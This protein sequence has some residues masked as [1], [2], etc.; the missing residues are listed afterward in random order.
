MNKEIWPAL[1]KE[2]QSR[3]EKGLKTYGRALTPFNARNSLQ[4]A[5]EESLDLCAYLKQSIEE[6]DVI[7][8]FLKKVCKLSDSSDGQTVND[9]SFEAYTLLKNLGEIR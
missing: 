9:L 5:I 3:H 1:I 6:R 2:M 8:D 4:D 7:V